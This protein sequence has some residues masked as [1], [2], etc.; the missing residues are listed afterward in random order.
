[1]T[2]PRAAAPREKARREEA[3][4]LDVEILSAI[5]GGWEE[6]LSENEFD[7][8]VRDVFAHQFRFLPAYRQLCEL[9]GVSAPADVTSWRGIPPV[10][11]GAFKVGRWTTFPPEAEV[12]AFRTSGTMQGSSGVHRL[13]TLGLANAAILK[14]ARRYVLPDRERIRCLF[15]SPRP[16]VAAHSSLVHMFAVYLEAF[17]EP[18]SGFLF[19]RPG[20]GVGPGA[21]PPAL[22]AAAPSG[23]PVLVAGPALAW[24]GVLE[25]SGASWA[26]PEGSRSLVTGG[27][28]GTRRRTSPDELAQVIEE[29]LGIPRSRQ[30]EEYGMTEL[31]SQF[32]DAG[33]RREQG[34][35]D[36]T[37]AG[38]RVPPWMR[39]R[40]I[41]PDTGHDVEDGEPGAI[42]HYDLANRGSAMVVQTSDVGVAVDGGFRLIGREPGAEA[43]GCSLAAELWFER[44]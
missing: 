24:L 31:S 14:S 36:E 17:G 3:E 8:L 27:F 5:G 1:M 35:G 10:P 13:D 44:V 21:V 23:E 2:S 29:R 42:V 7:R 6:P 30:V 4:R 43:R 11:A 18:G 16:S 9:R 32:Y 40:I 20:R 25:L 15:L 26:L 33:L 28:K 34:F 37:G 12:V 38:F 41:D 19:D 22:D 39:V